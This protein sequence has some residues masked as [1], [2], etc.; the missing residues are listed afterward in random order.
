MTWTSRFEAVELQGATVP[1]M[2]AGVAARWG[3][4]PA[5]V[6]G[7]SGAVM[8]HGELRRR[9]E[10]V[11][12][13]LGE[14]GVGP[15]DV[16]ALQAP[17][18]PEWLEV[19]L[20]T[21]KAGAVATGIAPQASGPEIEAHLRDTG[22]SVF[23]ATPELLPAARE[24]S[25][26]TG[27]RELVCLEDLRA[28]RALVPS[29]TPITGDTPAFLAMSSGTTGLPKPV[30]LTH[31]NLVIALGQMSSAMRPVEGEV[32]LALAPLTHIMGLAVATLLPLSAGGSA[33]TM[34][35]FDLGAMLELVERHRVTVLVV[36]PPVMNALAHHP[37]VDAHDLSSLELIVCGG[38]PLSAELQTA[39]GVRLP[40]TVVGQGYGMT[41]TT[42]VG[43]LPDRARGTVP[44]SVGRVAPREELRIVDPVSGAD[45]GPGEL[46]EVLM[47]GPQIMPG[48]L[49]R[50]EATAAM[51]DDE[52]WLRSGDLGFVGE[53]GD[54]FLVDRL[55]E[56]IKVSANQVSPT[57]L[58]TV[59][60]SHPAVADA[61]VIARPHPLHGEVP[62]A[63]VVARDEVDGDELMAWVAERVSPY[64]RLRAV[65]FTAAIPRTPAGKILRRVLVEQDRQ[66][67]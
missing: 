42:A 60:A 52:G 6:D 50:P 55:K 67:A 14:L 61:A 40:H 54:V 20:G 24:A 37:E 16:V 11:A 58:E 26:A 21:M 19:A 53:E 62:I 15:G 13:G 49:S 43:T 2:L 33:V 12:G 56:L 7:V 23:A 57:E 66:P 51:I 30:V 35:R 18:C 38:A 44:G 9:V 39:V 46:G 3:D 10:R 31:A 29:S 4:R 17:N 63:V 32:G 36:P 59:L 28:R 34:P 25:A 1:E 47:R 22:A 48:Y 5:L 27:V 41:E 45:L 64:K 8:T 65:R